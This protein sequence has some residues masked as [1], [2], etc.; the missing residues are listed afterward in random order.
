MNIEKNLREKLAVAHHIIHYHGWDDLL[1]THL[2]VRIPETRHLLITPLNIPFEQVSASKLVKCTPE[3]E[4]VGSDQPSMMRQ[5]INIHGAI[6]KASDHIMSAMH[7]HSLYGA[8]VASLQQGL[9]F[10]TQHSLRFYDDIA[11][12]AFNGLALENEGDEIVRSL[13]DKNIMILRNHGLLTMGTSIEVALYRLYYLEICCE[14]QVNI[15]SSHAP[16][17]PIPDRVC[18]ETKKQF[19]AILTPEIEFQVLFDRVKAFSQVDYRD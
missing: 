18:R 17:T 12:H 3:G 11:Y 4:I 9:L 7:T 19:D 15:M 1:A 14:M 5:A 2:S 8:T 13:Q 16:V 6:Y 10:C